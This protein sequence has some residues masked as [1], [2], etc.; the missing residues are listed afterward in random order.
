MVYKDGKVM[1]GTI[2][3]QSSNKNKLFG[4]IYKAPL[5]PKR[6]TNSIKVT[7]LPSF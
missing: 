5:K 7:F 2:I 1:N 6:F 4:K 3:F